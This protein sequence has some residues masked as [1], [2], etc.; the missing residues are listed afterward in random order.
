MPPSTGA[1]LRVQRASA[2]LTTLLNH[3]QAILSHSASIRCKL[4]R[5]NHLRM[6]FPH[7]QP[8]RRRMEAYQ[9]MMNE[10]VQ[11]WESVEMQIEE[12]YEVIA[13]CGWEEGEEG[14]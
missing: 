9:R 8:L 7:Y 2:A 5:L 6:L 10:L 13:I 4:I 14:A 3:K 12:N 1:H 11:I